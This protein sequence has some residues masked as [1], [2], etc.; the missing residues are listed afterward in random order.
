MGPLA[1]VQGQPFTLYLQVVSKPIDPACLLHLATPST[2]PLLS[3][4]PTEH[5]ASVLSPAG[6]R[7]HP[8]SGLYRQGVGSIEDQGY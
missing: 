2:E 6:P 3:T 7:P 5:L 4:H 1:S 8:F